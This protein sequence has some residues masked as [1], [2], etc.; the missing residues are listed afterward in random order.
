MNDL[1]KLIW[2]HDKLGD[3]K[4]FLLTRE[5]LDEIVEAAHELGTRK[6][7]LRSRA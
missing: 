2:N 7:S 5:E 1:E 3:A 6:N 4:T